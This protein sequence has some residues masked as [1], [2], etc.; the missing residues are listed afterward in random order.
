MLLLA[1][2][3]VCAINVFCYQQVAYLARETARYAAVHA[4]QYQKENAAAI[5]AGTL[6][7]VRR[8]A[9]GRPSGVQRAADSTLAAAVDLFT[10]WNTNAGTDPN[11]TANQSALTTAAANG[12]PNNG[13]T[14]TVTVNIPSRVGHVCRPEG[15]RGRS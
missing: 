9:A 7:N 15:C 2:L 11:G 10:K 1:G 8:R 5:T 3:V 13:T 12:C 4:G 14:A 6:P